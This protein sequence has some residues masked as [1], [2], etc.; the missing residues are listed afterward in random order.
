M[1]TCL[2]ILTPKVFLT[3]DEISRWNTA[4]MAG[5]PMVVTYSF[6]HTRPDYDDI[7]TAA[8]SRFTERHESNIRH[9]LDAWEEIS[10]LTFLE[11]E[12]DGQIGFGMIDESAMITRDFTAAGFAY[13]PHP[14]VNNSTGERLLY[15]ENSS[16]GS[17]AISGDVFFNADLYADDAE[18]LDPTGDSFTVLLHEIGHALGLEHT[19]E[20]DSVIDPDHDNTDTSVLSYTLGDNPNELGTADI[21]AI[22]FLYGTQAFQTS[23]NPDLQMVKQV[24]TSA[25]EQMHGTELSDFLFGGS[26]ADTLYGWNGDDFIVGVS[27]GTVDGGYGRDT[28]IF[29]SGNNTFDDLGGV[30]LG[31]TFSNDT[32]EIDDYYSG[33]FGNDFANGGL[34]NDVLVGDRSSQFI[35]GN[36]TLVGGRGSD[37][38]QGGANSDV[39]RFDEYDSLNLEGH[40]LGPD[41]IGRLTENQLF[42]AFNTDT[43]T[44]TDLISIAT[45]DFEVGI[46]I[47]EIDELSNSQERQLRSSFSSYLTDTADGVV[48]DYAQLEI[49]I[50][51]V[52]EAELLSV[53]FSDVIQFL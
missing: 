53:A 26:G 25:T 23:F 17:H 31:D 14:F 48:L 51:D 15:T 37:F 47:I 43:T 52:T 42:N 44:I 16:L 27:G 46:D 30:L 9:A 19:F 49:L 24:G 8:F 22:Q 41:V 32:L 33:G 28:V 39:F 50:I 1:S 10:G 2:Y 34:G 36:D 5:V 29:A 40:A 11:L 38:L 4:L 20:G 21:E 13:L 45:R 7:T 12:S 18:R 35:S 3:D 6:N